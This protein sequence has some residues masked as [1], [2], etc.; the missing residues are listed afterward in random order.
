MQHGGFNV[1]HINYLTASID[2]VYYPQL[3]VIG[4]IANSIYQLKEKIPR[5]NSWDFSYF[6][7]V[8]KHVDKSILEGADDQRFPIYPQRLVHDVRQVICQMMASSH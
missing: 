5:Q 2:P 6:L 8:K 7:E 1:I 4:D 3:G